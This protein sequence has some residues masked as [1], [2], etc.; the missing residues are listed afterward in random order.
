[1]QVSGECYPPV[2]ALVNAANLKS[3]QVLLWLATVADLSDVRLGGF[4][5]CCY[6]QRITCRDAIKMAGLTFAMHIFGEVY[7]M[8]W[9]PQLGA[10]CLPS[11]TLAI[12]PLIPAVVYAQ[13]QT[14]SASLRGT[15]TDSSGAIISG[16][17]VTVTGVGNGIVRTL[18]TDASGSYS[19]RLLPPATYNLKA[20]AKGFKTYQQ[21]G[22]SLLPGQTA[23]QTVQLTVGSEAEQITVSS[24]A[25]L[26]NTS[27][28]NLSAEITSKQVVDLPLNLRNV[29]GLATLNSSVQNTSESQKV[30]NGSTGDTADQ[31]ISFLNFGGGFFGTTAFLLDG[32]WDTAS[33]WGAVIYVP[34]VESVEEFKIQTNSFTAQYGFSTGNVINVVTK[35]G[36]SDVHGDIFEFLRN[37]KLDAN[38]YFNNFNGLPKPSFRRN[39]FG[40]SIG[41]PLF[42]PKF[43]EQ[44]QKTFFFALYE[45]LRQST[46]ATFTGTVPTPAFLSGDFSALLGAQTGTDALGRP[47]LAG[48]IYNPYSGRAI[49][50]GRID[51]STGLVASS[52]GYIR[53]PFINNQAQS[54]INPVAAALAKFWPA[55]TNAGIANNF[56]STASA[57]ATSDEYL[58][59]I[60]HNINDTT[61]IYGR[62]AQKYESKT[63]SPAFYGANDIGGPGNIRPN[64]RYSFVIGGN[65]IVNATTALSLNAGI[66]RWAEVSNSQGYPFD[67]TSVGLPGA[68]NA[69]SPVFPIVNV[70]GLAALGPVQGNQ[71]ASYRNVG[72]LSADVTKT[73][74]KHDLSFGFFGAIMQNNSAN[75]ATTTFSFDHGF[76][77]GPDPTQTTVGTGLGFASLLVGTPASGSTANEFNPALSK[78]YYGVY[79][80]DNWK[81]NK[82]LTLNLGLRYEIQESPTERHNRQTF[83][84]YN[85]SNP[86]SQQIGT[87]LPGE[88]VYAGGTQRRGL[89]NTNYLNVSPRFG[90]TAQVE[91][92]LVLRGGYGIFFAPQFFGGGAGF[93]DSYAAGYNQSTNYTASVNGNVS[94][95]T[96][97]SNPFPTGLIAPTGN[98]LGALQDVGL[99]TQGNPSSRHSPY[100]QQYS[101]GLQYAFTTNDVLTATFVGNHGTHLLMSSF[102]HS[103]LNPALLSMGNAL[104]DQVPNPYY[105]HITQSSC[106]LNNPTVERG[107]LLEPYSQYCSVTEPQAPVGFSIYNA[108]LVDYNHRFHQG[109]NL[110]VSY[111]YS[112]FLDNVDGANDWAIA[113]QAG[114]Q[115]YYNL[116]AE[117]SVDGSD[118]PHSLVANYIYELPVGK[119]RKFGSHMNRAVDEV[120]GGWQVSGVTSVKSGIPLGFSGGSTSNLFGGNARPDVIANPNQPGKNINKWFNTAAFTTPAPYTFGNTP[121]FFSTLRS[122]YYQNWDAAA[123]KYWYLH[124][125]IRLQGRAEFYNLANHPNFYSP[126]TNLPDVGFGTIRQ[127]FPNR[128]IQFALKLYW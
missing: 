3:I 102:N 9:K 115:N 28:A 97:L 74:G 19:A 18:T 78:K 124:N 91:P 66:E 17:K 11:L 107:Q 7:A 42:I 88:Q 37:D 52:T 53:D 13:G 79:A 95:F 92:K 61:R 126:D 15:V 16:A 116:A 24:Q 1:M 21:E 108:L 104:L 75:L 87:D 90:F 62:W 46:P 118:T 43:Y 128:S 113:G 55:P 31:D 105:G 54:A 29:Y 57:A 36:S 84:N 12:L 86:I 26:L 119:G 49:T 76:T 23:D 56:A 67:Q 50:E 4:Y 64:N 44:R 81:A 34:S 58:V 101:L 72:S 51:P 96:N 30:N 93:G 65:H 73:A 80:Q 5:R 70:E 112:K 41:G 39:Q 99:T 48:Q 114:P 40:G 32:V 25:P 6:S 120:V 77:A 94:P 59:R 10:A 121:R 45:G 122:P 71:G 117:K 103:Q 27:D 2:E 14:T 98:T 47:I 38:P 83:F 127:A 89:A 22:I 85:A 68:L 8:K 125:Q 35:S 123:E 33:D 69:A 110:L 111:T 100:I 82:V 109:L 106:G 60:D 20:E 63:N